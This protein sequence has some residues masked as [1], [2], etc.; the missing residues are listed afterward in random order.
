MVSI[1]YNADI[2]EQIIRDDLKKIVNQVYKLLPMREEKSDWQKP[3]ETLMVQ[4]G[5]MNRLFEDQQEVFFPLLC[6]MEGLFTLTEEKDFQIYRR[7]IFECLGL[8][9]IINNNVL[10]NK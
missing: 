5:G 9:N 3:L 8:L 1:K 10:R 6:K 7:T 4:L 2:K